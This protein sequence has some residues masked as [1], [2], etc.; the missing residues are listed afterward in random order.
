MLFR[1]GKPGFGYL[2]HRLVFISDLTLVPLPSVTDK[3]VDSWSAELE[4]I[5]NGTTVS[6]IIL[7]SYGKDRNK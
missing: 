2:C 1:S 3:D 5:V 7:R 6:S 4:E